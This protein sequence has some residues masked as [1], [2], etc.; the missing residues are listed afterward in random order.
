MY[1]G[2]R[3]L[4]GER[5]V[6]R[7]REGGGW[8]QDGMSKRKGGGREGVGCKQGGQKEG[9]MKAGWQETDRERI[10]I[11]LQSISSEIDSRFKA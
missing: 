10:H 4:R 11:L 1:C 3:F 7:G 9:R 2:V 5:G 8:K 6:E